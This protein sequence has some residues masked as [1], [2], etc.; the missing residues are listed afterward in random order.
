M[1]AG[2]TAQFRR[3]LIKLKKRSKQVISVP[4]PIENEPTDEAENLD[5][6]IKKDKKDKLGTGK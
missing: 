6:P 1:A 5:E 2:K 4:V 3:D